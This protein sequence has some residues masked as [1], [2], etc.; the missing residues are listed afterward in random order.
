MSAGVERILQRA[1][2]SARAGQPNPML[3]LVDASDLENGDHPADHGTALLMVMSVCG[4]SLL[5]WSEGQRRKP[6][7]NVALLEEALFRVQMA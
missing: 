5:Q 3:A 6:E 4:G 7:E 1:I 2:Q